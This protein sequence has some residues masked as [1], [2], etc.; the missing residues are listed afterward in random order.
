MKAPC[1]NWTQVV[2]KSSS[3]HQVT[4][5]CW[6]TLTSA[7]QKGF[8][9]QVQ[10]GGVSLRRVGR[11]QGACVGVVRQSLGGGVCRKVQS[12][13]AGRHFL[14][15]NWKMCIS[16]TYSFGGVRCWFLFSGRKT[17]AVWVGSRSELSVSDGPVNTSCS[18]C[19]S[20]MSRIIA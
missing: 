11:T 19:S 13:C 8:G 17:L 5:L 9:F 14:S 6:S 18:S 7:L 2:K 4:A 15:L 20:T 16:S 12:L 1:Y 3:W 10:L